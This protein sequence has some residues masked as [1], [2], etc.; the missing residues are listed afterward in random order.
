MAV[1]ALK[2]HLK[3]D[4]K[5]GLQRTLNASQLPAAPCIVMS[6]PIEWLIACDVQRRGPSCCTAGSK[7]AALSAVRKAQG[8]G[9][10]FRHDELSEH[11][12]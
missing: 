6:E 3:E 11:A 7:P 1:Q 5:L 10:G 12:T 4:M 2:R 9:P 8:P